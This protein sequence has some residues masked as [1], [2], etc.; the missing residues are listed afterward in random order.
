[1]QSNETPRMPDLDKAL[2]DITAIRSQIARGTEFRGY[3]PATVAVTGLFA[4]IAAGLQA[5]WLPDPAAAPLGYLA[6]WIAT[7]LLSAVLIGIEMIARTRR[8]HPG[9]A[10]E[11]IHAAIEQLIPAGVAG[12]ML[13]FVI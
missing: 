7:A 5:L 2:A 6:L 3:G 1:M 4:L 11:M 13:T 12:A 9:F 10:D 8:V